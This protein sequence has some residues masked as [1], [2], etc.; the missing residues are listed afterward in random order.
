VLR[1]EPD[2]SRLEVFA[3]GLRNPQE[4]AFNELGDLFTG[5]NNSDGG[6][7]ARWVH[8]VEG[9]DSGWRIGYQFIETPVSRGPWNTEKLWHPR[10]DGQAAYVIPPIAN[11]GDGPSGLAYYPGTGLPPRYDGHFFLCDFRGVSG[12]SG[13]RT[14]ALEKRGASYEMTDQHPF[15]WSVL[16]TD[17]DFGPDGA[18]YISDWVTGWDKTG[19]GRIY[20]V[21]DPGLEREPRTV[22]VRRLLAE[23]M[24]RRSTAETVLLLEHADMRVRQEAQF[25]L[26]ERGF[27]AMPALFGVAQRSESRLAR[28]HATW[29]L[30]QIARRDASVASP[31]IAL[32]DQEDPEVR[33]QAARVLGDAG[34]KAARTKLVSLLADPEPR[35]RYFA[36]MGLA[37]VGRKEDVAPLLAL[38]R[39]NADRDLHVRH[40][41]VMALAAVRDADLLLAAAK[42]V[43]DTVRLGLLLALRRLES[44]HVA[45]FLE[46]G[47]ERLVVEAARA[48]NDVPI[49]SAL[50]HLAALPLKAG[51]PD[52]LL[53]R[54][55]NASFRLGMAEHASI[56]AA[57]AARDDLTEAI[58][59][60]ALAELAQWAAPSGRDR[61]MGLWRPLGPRSAEVAANALRRVLPG[62][63]E[64]SPDRIRVAAIEAAAQLGLKDAGKSLHAVIA[65]R[66]GAGEA[67]AAALKALEALGDAALLDAARAAVSDA[68]LRLRLE[69]QRILA[70]LRPV[71]AV[72]VLE[73]ALEH[74]TTA[75]R[76]GALASL[77]KLKD[78]RTA[79][80]LS[81]WMDRLLAGAVP[82]EIELDLLEAAAIEG[83]PELGAKLLKRNEARTPGDPTAPFRE[84]LAGGDAGRGKRVF[85]EKKEVSCQ[86]CHR[87]EG[88]GGEVGPSL[89]GIGSREKREHILE[90]LIAPNQKITKGYDTVALVTTEGK[91]Y[92]GVL[93][94]EDDRRVRIT[95]PQGIL[96]AVPK[97][98]IAERSGGVSAMPEDVSKF[99]TKREIRDLVEYLASLK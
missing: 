15:V 98:S 66:E 55:L 56:V 7:K 3:T 96:L 90:S 91:V 73:A 97:D 89:A 50:P 48:I 92:T 19:K 25:A 16:A 18:M 94:D 45:A 79:A 8:V 41:A 31:I 74:G 62:I 43:P 11:I 26:A 24:E 35:V 49:E 65:A 46:D 58:R 12:M 71:E 99:L 23:G 9:G 64:E 30:G 87:T 82:L 6:D 69:G 68:D 57:A 14:F 33:A 88:S 44:P 5:D 27:P 21:S 93:K 39:S 61:V 60:E 75:E 4:L 22:E 53:L 28:L 77:A 95:S 2:G 78:S 85:H 51:M 63:L 81:T 32:L 83:S 29:A 76:Q 47:E 1:C 20:R 10:W 80:I 37:R 84:C 34:A 40:A 59:A 72:R 13:I 67:R 36:A 54:V 38:L 86:R 42:D 52:V 17:C 70:R